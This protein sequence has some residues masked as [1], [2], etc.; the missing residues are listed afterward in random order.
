MY[1]ARSAGLGTHS[2]ELRGLHL[3]LMGNTRVIL[4]P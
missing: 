4:N 3:D 1:E 2:L